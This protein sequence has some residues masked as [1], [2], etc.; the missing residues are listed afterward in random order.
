MKRMFLF[1]AMA[2]VA[3]ASC[4]KN[5][6]VNF[7]QEDAITFS[8]P[9][10]GLNTKAV[11]IGTTYLAEDPHFGV[12]AHYFDADY[13]AFATGKLYMNNVEVKYE[14]TTTPWVPVANYYW[15]KN[16]TLTF[17]AYSPYGTTG[18]SYGATGFKFENYTVAD[19]AT[20]ADLL[21]SERTYDQA[22]PTDPNFE[23]VDLQFNHAL[24]S[25]V[26]TAKT[27]NAAYATDGFEFTL[28][29]I[30]VQKVAATG[31]FEQGLAD[32]DAAVTPAVTA[33][34]NK[35]WTV[36]GPAD[37]SYVAYTGG[38]LSLDNSVQTVPFTTDHNTHLI[39]LPQQL[40]AAELVVNYTVTN[41]NTSAVLEQTST[42]P[43][44]TATVS[45]WLRGKRYTYNITFGLEKIFFDEPSVTAWDPETNEPTVAY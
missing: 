24:A 2:C 21:Y 16:G 13:T 35:C 26:F 1:A 8:A 36:T 5:E 12:F 4:T 44:T 29:A 27:D 9:V 34:E 17:A 43:L 40:T 42:L 30:T 41:T 14:N 3:L 18:V 32:A 28:N 19:A 23:G 7:P 45:E 37:Q 15:P 39:L 22:K 20:Q 31:T 33:T 10:V 6:Q 38:S 11:E 25:V